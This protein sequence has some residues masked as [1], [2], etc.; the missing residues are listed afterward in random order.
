MGCK[1]HDITKSASSQTNNKSSK[2]PSLTPEFCKNIYQKTF[3]N[4]FRLGIKKA[5]KYKKNLRLG[6]DIC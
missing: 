3:L 5:K 2:K 4:D 6:G 1:C